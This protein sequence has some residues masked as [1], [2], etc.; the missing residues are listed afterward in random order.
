MTTTTK[1][2]LM[3]VV[4]VAAFF[5]SGCTTT[6]YVRTACIDQEQYERLRDAEPEKISDKLTGRADEDIRTIAGSAVRLR[7]WG[8][9]MLGVLEGCRG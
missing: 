8:R 9:G 1:F 6:R 5:L 4:Y 2:W 3:V 7:S